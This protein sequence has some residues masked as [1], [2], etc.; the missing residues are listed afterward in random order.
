MFDFTSLDLNLIWFILVGVLLAGYAMLD[1]FDLGVGALHLFTKT[2]EERRIMINSIGPVWDGNEVWLVTGG[3]A[4]FAAFPDVYAT[5]ASGFY[6]AVM[7]LLL[8]LIFRA[9]SIE[10]RSKQPMKWWRSFWDVCF[11]VS[12]IVASLVM[13]VAVGNLVWGIALDGAKNYTGS[14]LDLFNPYTLLIG[15]TTVALFM[16]HGSIYIVM[17]TEGEFQERLRPWINNCIIFF[18]MCFSITTVATLVYVPGMADKFRHYPLAFIIPLIN[19]FAIANI[20]REIFHRREF[21]ALISSCVAMLALIFLF[22]IGIFPN[23]VLS[24]PNPEYSLTVYNAASSQKGLNYMLNIALLG[25]PFVLSYTI[26][27]YWVFRG[28]VKLNED[29]Y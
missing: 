13:G 9:V 15:V 24:S 11:S 27:I 6:L 22:G 8:A 23:L 29:S 10:F 3:G 12:S 18:I 21:M 4:L 26:A 28:K 16:M 1:G 17:K 5:L 25:I 14:F 2:D 20:P 19:M 7:L